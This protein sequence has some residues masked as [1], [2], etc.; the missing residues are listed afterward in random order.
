MCTFYAET[1]KVS[2]SLSYSIQAI[3][4]ELSFHRPNGLSGSFAKQCFLPYKELCPQGVPIFSSLHPHIS[5]FVEYRVPF[6]Q[7]LLLPPLTP[8]WGKGNPQSLWLTDKGQESKELSRRELWDV[9]WY[10]TVKFLLSLWT[11]R[12]RGPQT[13]LVYHRGGP[14][15]LAVNLLSPPTFSLSMWIPGGEGRQRGGKEGRK[16]KWE[17]GGWVGRGEGKEGRKE[18]WKS[19]QNSREALSPEEKNCTV[20]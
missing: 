16:E 6:S 2:L 13:G 17:R 11:L 1:F 20:E 19:V 18:G 9:E 15:G 14:A 8:E 7:F 12:N 5:M 4:W 10:E 3:L